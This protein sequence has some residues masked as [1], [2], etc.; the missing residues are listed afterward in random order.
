[1]RARPDYYRILQV[2][3]LAEPEVIESAYKRLAKKYHPDVSSARDAA[4]RMK[5]INEAYEVLKDPDRRRAFDAQFNGQHREAA[6]K[7]DIRTEQNEES[8]HPAQDILTQYFSAIQ[9]RRLKDAYDLLSGADR[10]NIS[11][12]DF[13]KW[14]GAVAKV[15]HLEEFDCSAN[16]TA[17]NRRL[18]GVLYRRVAEF[19]VV[20]LEHNIVMNSLEKDI[21]SKYVVLEQDGWRIFLGYTDIKPYITKF[22]DL[23]ELLTAK[24]VISEMVE[25]Y[26]NRDHLSGLFNKKGFIEEAEKEIWRCGR[27]GN[28][29]SLMIL[30]AQA[31][32]RNEQEWKEQL[33]AW[34]GTLLKN[35]FRKLDVIGRWEETRFMILMPE[36]DL[37]GSLKAALKVKEA[38]ESEKLNYHGKPYKIS[39]RIGVDEFKGSL[40][41]TIGKLDQYVSAAKQRGNSVVVTSGGIYG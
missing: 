34:T 31:G 26:S 5:Q 20:T 33:I 37:T 24:E 35:R 16:K 29:F 1:M 27:Y 18:G 15:Y 19:S 21:I 32:K 36:T 38:F 10:R 7:E 30:E 2:H 8:A 6:E 13:A 40:E 17:D 14:Q 22:E 39:V 3:L 4:A 28:P 12:D 41:Q 9:D 11:A 23:S 25:F